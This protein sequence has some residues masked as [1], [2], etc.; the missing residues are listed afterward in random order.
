[1]VPYRELLQ[2]LYSH[3]NVSYRIKSLIMFLI[4]W[5]IFFVLG[6]VSTSAQELPQSEHVKSDSTWKYSRTEEAWWHS[7]G[8]DDSHWGFVEA[9][10]NGLCNALAKPFPHISTP[11]WAPN[12]LQGESVYFRKKFVLNEK[13]DKAVVE[14]V[15][16]D[17]GDVYVNGTLV[18]RDRSGTVN[19]Q[20]FENDV[21]TLLQSGE[22]VIG[23]FAI[24][25][26]GQ[27]QSAQV[28]LDL[29]LTYENLVLAVPLM[30]QLD[31]LWK[32]DVYAGGENDELQC[33]TNLGDC[34]CATTSLAMI[35]K[36][37]GAARSPDGQETTPQSLNSYL[38]RGQRCGSQG[39]ISLGYA[40][41]AL[42][43]AAAEQYSREAHEKYGT[44]KVEWVDRVEADPNKIKEEI[45][46]GAPVALKVGDASHWV[47]G[48]GLTNDDVMIRD[49][50][51]ERTLLSDITY[52]STAIAMTRFKKTNSDFRLVQVA[53]P[54]NQTIMIRDKQGR[55]TGYDVVRREEVR[56]IPNSTYEFEPAAVG[57]GNESQLTSQK[58][59]WI[60][61]VKLPESDEYT[62]DVNSTNQQG[63]YE[64]GVYASNKNADIEYELKQGKI[65]TDNTQP[66]STIYYDLQ[67]E[68]DILRVEEAKKP[69]RIKQLS[70]I[71]ARSTASVVVYASQTFSILDIHFDSVRLSGAQVQKITTK[72][73]N[74]DGLADVILSF[75]LRD[76]DLR[77]DSV[78]A[79][80]TGK[81]IDDE[82]FRRAYDIRLKGKHR[83]IMIGGMLQ[84]S[85]S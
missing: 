71:V 26:R 27:C 62:L 83:T 58:G 36:Y 61:S 5:A 76:T 38:K 1:M 25:T 54:I 78:R 6:G 10:S 45:R 4:L 32:D 68:K 55:R 66:E 74:K 48:Y 46:G 43:W 50:Y 2:V 22:N 67:A 11:M 20:V 35:L 7:L 69:K 59:A 85:D 44:Q 21:T 70:C 60:I 19:E 84:P 8:F 42:R 33:G 39:C 14:T 56:E 34:G 9:P 75:R 18:R 31:P 73:V 29:E 17:D 30:K 82:V 64:V 47:V 41:G 28:R 13:P 24:D 53:S 52:R 72:D 16:D 23:I 3:M 12:P 40:Y 63:T 77:C 81:K 80:L 57:A 79:I 49:P 51:Y 37:F 65:L 15:F